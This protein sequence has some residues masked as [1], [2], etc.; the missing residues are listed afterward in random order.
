MWLPPAAS[1]AVCP[2]IVIKSS[3]LLTKF[4]QK[5]A[6]PVWPDVE[7]KRN[8]IFPI[9][10]Q[11]ESNEILNWKIPF[12]KRAQKVTKYLGYFLKKICSQDFSKFAQSFQTAVFT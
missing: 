8:P 6:S 4:A 9:V 1:G 10:S 5:A 11:R 3:P 12:F 7:I 2:N